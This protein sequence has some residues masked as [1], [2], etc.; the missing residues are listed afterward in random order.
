MGVTQTLLIL[1]GVVVGHLVAVQAGINTRLAVHVGGAVQ[2]T[3]FSF[4][5][6]ALSLF[7]VMM[8]HPQISFPFTK[9]AATPWY[10]FLGGVCGSIFVTYIVFSAPKIGISLALAVIIAGQ[11]SG[12][13]L[14]EHYGLLGMERHPINFLRMLGVT[15][16]LGG[17]AL[18]SWS[19]VH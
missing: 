10:W 16:L 8:L 12:S 5:T 1:F 19:R 2:A 6:G 13:V 17:V 15:M 3:F 14:M 18:L 4:L 7:I 11:M 9:A